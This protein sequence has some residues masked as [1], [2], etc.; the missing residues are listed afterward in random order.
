[1]LARGPLVE[2]IYDSEMGSYLHG[3]TFGGHPVATAVAIA[4][5]QAMD[6]EG[7]L[8]NVLANEGYMQAKLDSLTE[9]HNHVLEWRGTGYF[10]AIELCADRANGVALSDS[11]AAQL[12]G[13]V[14]AKYVRDE[15]L[16]IRPDNRGATNLVISPPLIATTAVLDDIM[17][18][19]DSVLGRTAGWLTEN[20]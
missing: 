2:S 5:I 9:A 4:N 7:V 6:D 11:Q 1:M 18:R 20:A 10:Y 14:L 13:G 12:Q 15:K 8:Q 17:E 3:S 19:V 16:L